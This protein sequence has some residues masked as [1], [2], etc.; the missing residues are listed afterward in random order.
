MI[1]VIICVFMYVFVFSNQV[2]LSTHYPS[3]P[4]RSLPHPGVKPPHSFPQFSVPSS[5]IPPRPYLQS[6]NRP[7]VLRNSREFSP[8][9]EGS[10]RDGER[11]GPLDKIE[12]LIGKFTC[13][14]VYVCLCMCVCV[15]VCVPLCLCL[16]VYE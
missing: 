9:S 4:S 12:G 14:D 7:L 10:D 11:G 5:V 16:C 3:I 15:C 6:E 13:E 2:D 8:H 1:A